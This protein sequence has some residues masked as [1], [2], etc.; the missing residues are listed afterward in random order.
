ML[1]FL[2]DNVGDHLRAAVT[3]VLGDGPM[4]FEQAIF[5]DGL[6]PDSIDS[7]RPA[8]AAHWQA[9]LTALVPTF[10]QSARVNQ[11]T[12]QEK[13]K[14]PAYAANQAWNRTFFNDDL[15]AEVAER[16]RVE[17]ALR[18]ALER[19]ELELWYQPEVDLATGD[20]EA[21]EPAEHAVVRRAER[22][23]RRSGNWCG[24]LDIHASQPRPWS[25]PPA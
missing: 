17:Q 24:E 10:R 3:N 9:L 12:Y 20:V 7:V 15:R 5:A 1:G 14:K 25:R 13:M 18:G 16:L 2:G 8:V 4:Q 11:A 19:E 22:Y 6:T 21:V 23:G